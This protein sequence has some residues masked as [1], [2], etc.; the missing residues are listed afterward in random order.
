MER[1]LVVE[2]NRVVNITLSRLLENNNY[3]VDS[4]FSAEEAMAEIN[5][6]KYDLI[7]LDLKL[8]KMNGY[9]FL[10]V[11]LKKSKVQVIINTSHATVQTRVK[12]I[13]VGASDF[14]EKAYSTEEILESIRLVLDEHK[15]QKDRRKLFTYKNVEIDFSSRTVIK[16]GKYIDLTIKEFEILKML[17]ESPNRAFTRKQIYLVVWGKEYNEVVDNT[18]NVHV[19]R[20]RDKI[21]DNPKDPDIVETVYKYGYRLGKPV[22]DILQN[23]NI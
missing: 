19:R 9:A 15:K 17:F 23:K 14:I 16:D 1:I 12:L 10:Q 8:P 13:N 5:R 4:V 3:L 2:D 21:E 7:L 11:L 22:V 20:L 18:I 6:R